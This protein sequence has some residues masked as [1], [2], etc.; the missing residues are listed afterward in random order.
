M[1]LCLFQKAFLPAFVPESI[2]QSGEC[3]L[4][5][6]DAY[7]KTQPPCNKGAESI[8]SINTQTVFNYSIIVATRPEPTVRPP[9]RFVENIIIILFHVFH[10]ILCLYSPISAMLFE[11]FKFFRTKIEPQHIC[12]E[13]IHWHQSMLPMN[14]FAWIPP[15]C[16]SLQFRCLCSLLFLL[17]QQVC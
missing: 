3:A 11:V 12:I 2:L 10:W 17:L 6:P 8:K 16:L 14:L 7:K 5:S 15:E 9:S 4:T 13:T 1:R